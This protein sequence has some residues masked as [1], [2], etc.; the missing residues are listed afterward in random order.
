MVKTL[1]IYN[2]EPKVSLCGITEGLEI[3]EF[4]LKCN[5]DAE[6]HVITLRKNCNIKQN[7]K[8]QRVLLG[9]NSGK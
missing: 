8:S 1:K 4:Y 7:E 6:N 5:R 2:K 3:S 9:N